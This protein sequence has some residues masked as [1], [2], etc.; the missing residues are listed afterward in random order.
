MRALSPQSPRPAKSSSTGGAAP[1]SGQRHRHRLLPE[2]PAL[3]P[4]LSQRAPPVAIRTAHDRSKAKTRARCR[5]GGKDAGRSH[6]AT[7]SWRTP[8]SSCNRSW[9]QQARGEPPR[10][11]TPRRSKPSSGVQP[12][13]PSASWRRGPGVNA[14]P[15]LHWSQLASSRP[16]PARLRQVQTSVWCSLMRTPS[17]SAFR[18]ARVPRQRAT[19]WS[20]VWPDQ[21][22]S[23]SASDLCD[24]VSVSA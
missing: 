16:V 7:K 10:G 22:R 14:P 11:R 4:R 21:R 8:I 23:P 18:P 15:A 24:V 13:A 3:T 2:E 9:V 1:L 17:I 19:V 5:S 12:A 6:T 20:L